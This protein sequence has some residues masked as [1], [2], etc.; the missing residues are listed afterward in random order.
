MPVF[1]NIMA[2]ASAQAS[3][4]LGEPIEQSL[5]FNGDS[6]LS[7]AN[8]NA[9]SGDFTIS[10]WWKRAI[11]VTAT[12]TFFLWTPNQA[13]QFTQGNDDRPASRVSSFNYFGDASM[14]D[15][16][17]WYHLVFVNNSGNT[18]LYINGVQQRDTAT[19]PSGSG[20]MTIGSNSASS[21]DDK[22][23]GYLAEFNLFDGTLLTADDFGRYNDDGVWVPKKIEGE[24]TSAQYGA[25]GFRLTFASDQDSTASTAIGIDSAPT[26]TGHTSANN[27]TATG[28]DTTAISSANRINDIDIKDTPTSNYA[29]LNPLWHRTTSLK[30]ANL[31]LTTAQTITGQSTFRFPVGTT[32]KYWVE[33]GTANLGAT[34]NAPALCITDQL[35][36]AGLSGT[37]WSTT[38]NYSSIGGYQQ[39]YSNFTST[40]ATSYTTAGGQV[41]MAIDFDAEEVKMY[42][43]STLINTDT[44]VDFTKE[45]AITVMQPTTSYDTYEPY[46]N[47]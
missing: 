34:T 40:S 21:Q 41:G 22:L 32:G 2:G 4:D 45:L 26:G 18:T 46:L 31:A 9:P 44:T 33:A 37:A 10:F 27:F 25:K 36:A 29:L 8:T 47:A 39:S 16:S 42:N 43:N 13:Y 23:V 19:T 17:A 11:G 6:R 3:A 24:F 1:N 7:C 38:A 20:D 14:R 15:H 5:R 12:H 35:D 30:E 28:F